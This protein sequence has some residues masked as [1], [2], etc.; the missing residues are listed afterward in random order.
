MTQ[1][2][3]GFRQGALRATHVHVDPQ[4][5]LGD[6]PLEHAPVAAAL[7][8]Q[9][10]VADHLDDPPSSQ[11]IDD[12]QRNAGGQQGLQFSSGGDFG[13]HRNS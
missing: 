3:L 4:Q 7:G 5:T 10:R 2:L 6:R 12:H 9:G 8:A 11:L 13:G 1:Q